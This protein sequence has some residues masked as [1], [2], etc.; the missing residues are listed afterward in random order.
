VIDTSD[1]TFLSFTR[2]LTRNG[3]DRDE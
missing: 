3:V 2:Q 1:V